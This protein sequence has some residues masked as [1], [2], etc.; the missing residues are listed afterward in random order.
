MAVYVGVEASGGVETPYSIPNRMM[1]PTK[2][3]IA[4]VSAP[5]DKL[6]NSPVAPSAVKVLAMPMPPAINE[7]MMRELFSTPLIAAMTCYARLPTKT[8]QLKKHKA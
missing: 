4:Q 1:N 3:L 8:L 6:S 2:K 7:R 5:V